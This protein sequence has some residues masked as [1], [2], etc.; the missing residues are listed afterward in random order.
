MKHIL[1]TTP[2]ATGLILLGTGITH[3]ATP[4]EIAATC[5]RATIPTTLCNGTGGSNPT[6]DGPGRPLKVDPG[7]YYSG[8]KPDVIVGYDKDK[9][10]SNE[11]GTP[12]LDKDGN[13]M[14]QPITAP[15]EPIFTQKPADPDAVDLSGYQYK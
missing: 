4:D 3:A 13:Q 14:Y 12:K 6:N 10:L 7:K 2:I 1:F 11:D 9:P 8:N 5:A 15:G